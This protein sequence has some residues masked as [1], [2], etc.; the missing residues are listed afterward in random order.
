MPCSAIGFVRPMTQ[1]MFAKWC[2][3]LCL[4]C[5]FCARTQRVCEI[6]AKFA[7]NSCEFR[8]GHVDLPSV[9]C[10]P[11][12]PSL[13]V[14]FT[15]ESLQNSLQHLAPGVFSTVSIPKQVPRSDSDD[16][17]AATETTETTETCSTDDFSYIPQLQAYDLCE[18]TTASPTRLRSALRPASNAL[19]GIG[20]SVTSVVLPSGR[21]KGVSFGRV[22]SNV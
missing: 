10:P 21:P 2:L 22:E 15:F 16:S 6:P 5:K 14:L 11:P 1:T 13:S 3:L 19:A 9:N 18:A 8:P 20:K 12:P 4:L 17:L 7:R